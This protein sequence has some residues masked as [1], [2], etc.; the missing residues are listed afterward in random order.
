MGFVL[1]GRNVIRPSGWDMEASL[2]QCDY[3]H[4][5]SGFAKQTAV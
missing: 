1:E 2:L 4:V 5:W 3:D